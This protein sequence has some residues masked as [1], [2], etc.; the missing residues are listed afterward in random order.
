MNFSFASIC[1][2]PLFFAKFK[3]PDFESRLYV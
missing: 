1:F 3:Y 2:M